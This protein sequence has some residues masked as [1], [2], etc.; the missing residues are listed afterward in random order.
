MGAAIHI[1]SGVLF[2]IGLAIAGMTQ[3]HKVVGFLDFAGNWIPDL[4]VVMGGAV[5]VNFI[6]LHLTLK[7]DSPILAVHFG[8]PTRRDLNPRLMAG[9]ALFGAGWGLGGFCPGPALA[10]LPT[11]ATPVIVFV[12][13]MIAGMVGFD[14]IDRARASRA[15]REEAPAPQPST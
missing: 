13:A 8:L 6:A 4:A 15:A 14:L 1:L 3:P 5:V 11:A 9:A 7:R 2:A 12:A 10:S